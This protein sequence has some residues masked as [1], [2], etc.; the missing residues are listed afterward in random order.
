MGQK[1][2]PIGFRLCTH[3]TTNSL[4]YSSKIDYSKNL[5]Q[6]C[7]IRSYIEKKFAHASISKILIRR[8]DG[9]IEIILYSA[10]PGVIVGKKGSDI[11]KLKL[12]L[13]KS[14]NSNI[15][16]SIIEVKKPNL[17][18]ALVAQSI[19]IQIEKRFS[20]RRVIKKAISS[21]IRESGVRGIKVICSGRLSGA[22]IA[23]TEWFK[24]GAIP[25]QTLR[26]AIDFSIAEAHTTYGVIGI[27]V[28]IYTG[29]TLK[30]LRKSIRGSDVHSEDDQI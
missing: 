25:L 30:K 26:A 18:A 28:Y 24:E 21:V 13:S 27:K 8:K 9:E 5:Y 11:E 12:F 23:R 16:I 3:N 4:W 29:D 10:K 7:Y 20:F 6:D 1:V 22:E 2:N 15:S 19:K 14:L 17:S